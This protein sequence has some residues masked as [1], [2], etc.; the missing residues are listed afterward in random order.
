ML[1]L[2]RGMAALEVLTTVATVVTFAAIVVLTAGVVSTS[3]VV[4]T[5]AAVVGGTVVTV[6]TMFVVVDAIALVVMIDGST[7]V[8]VKAAEMA[9]LGGATIGADLL[10]IFLSMVVVVSG[11]V[12][13]GWTVTATESSLVSFDAPMSLGTP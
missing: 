7:V 6:V 11:V 4:V 1:P 12:K 8:L 2:V 13:F 3:L 5:G 9:A 10:S